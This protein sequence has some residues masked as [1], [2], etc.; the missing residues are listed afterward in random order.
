MEVVW[1]VVLVVLGLMAWGGQTISLVDPT[2][3]ARWNLTEAEETVEP[4]YWADIRG[5]T[6][7]DFYTL[8]TLPVAGIL[9]IL[10]AASWTTFGLVGGGV[11]VYFAGR[12]ILTRL[13]L[14]RRGFR[15]G[16]PAKF[17]LGLVMLGVWG[18][19]GLITVVAA[20]LW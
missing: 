4:A 8:W 16:D 11:Y 14:H 2:R 5:E 10:D 9:L 12:G 1:G 13:E 15:I 18:L 3:A 19:A 7:W 6:L 17:R 20:I